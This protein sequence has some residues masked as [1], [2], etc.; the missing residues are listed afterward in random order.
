[1]PLTRRAFNAT[2]AALAAD[3]LPPALVRRHDEALDRILREQTPNGSYP[4]EFG[5][6]HPGTA[7]G[8]LDSAMAALVCPQS[9]HYQS[10]EVVQRVLL[11]ARFLEQHQHSDGTIDLLATNFHSTPDL[12]FVVHNTAAA[13]ALARAANQRE[14]FAAMEPFLRKAMEALIVGG[15]HTP[16]HRWV[17]C[18]A[19]AQLNELFPD[20]RLLRRIDQW[21][22]EG[23]DIDEDGQFNERST[24]VYNPVTDKAL[25]V[26]ALKLKRPA[27]LEP[28]RRNLNA[29]LYLLHPNGEVVTE[30]STRQDQYDRSGPE[31]YWFPL[32]YLAVT[33]GNGQYAELVRR[34]EE[35]GASLS[36]YL[37]Y[38]ELNKPLPA[39]KPLPDDFHKLMPSVGIARVRRGAMSAS[40]LLNGNARFF[41]M[42][43]GECVVEAVRFASAFFGKGQFR[44]SKWEPV[45][46][47]YKLTQSMEGPYYQ[48]VD[49]PHVVD[50]R[51][52]G[53]S[54]AER[55]HSEVQHLTYSVIL[56]QKTHGFAIE[57][58]ANGTLGVPISIEVNLRSNAKLEGV[59]PAG[60]LPDSF[61]LKEGYATARV[62]ADT[63]RFGPGKGDHSWTQVRGAEPKLRENSVYLCGFTPFKHTLEITSAG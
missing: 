31:R 24:T 10:R 4:D 13:A 37:R 27:L 39:P 26:S 28:V 33:E 42:R 49:P 15:V 16:N 12:G 5:I 14:C 3:P 35:K 19:M 62:G 56:R 6:F 53:A 48:P 30:I 9:R 47:G 43:H 11:A 20:P 58:D 54:R 25:L 61:L 50:A 45:D 17:V 36:A 32:R 18:E 51:E 52:W 21:M 34:I 63:I 22:G 46:G 40:I 7:S 57:I 60:K 23:I 8:I 1:M 38:P 55:R 59:V 29:L 41:T 2:L 44:A